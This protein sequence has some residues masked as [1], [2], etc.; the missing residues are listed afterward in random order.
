[1]AKAKLL[2]VLLLLFALLLCWCADD[3]V[4]GAFVWA[5]CFV[6]CGGWLV[7]WLVGCLEWEDC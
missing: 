5:C 6:V 3:D 4:C 2:C 7:E 1:M